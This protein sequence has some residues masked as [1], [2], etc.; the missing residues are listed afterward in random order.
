MEQ[1]DTRLLYHI[2][3]SNTVQ[4]FIPVSSS[5]LHGMEKQGI[6]YRQGCIM[7]FCFRET[8]EEKMYEAFQNYIYKK[9]EERKEI[10]EGDGVVLGKTK[11][12]WITL[13]MYP[14][15]I[16]TSAYPNDMYPFFQHFHKLCHCYYD[17]KVEEDGIC[18][19]SPEKARNYLNQVPVILVGREK[20][21]Q[22][23]FV[24]EFRNLKRK[25]GIL[26]LKYHSEV[27][28]CVSTGT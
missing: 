24:H 20:E 11:R 13:D 25:E 23:G 9:K 4:K 5:K 14:K 17:E 7:K 26:F 8:K 19:M 12:Q 21:R 16:I 1:F 27:M 22:Y 15:W 10:Y 6:T 18:F 3:N 28:E 2:K